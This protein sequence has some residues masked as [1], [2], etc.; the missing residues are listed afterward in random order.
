MTFVTN[1]LTTIKTKNVRKK[2]F[3]DRRNRWLSSKL[4]EAGSGFRCQMVLSGS[5]LKRHWKI[6]L[7]IEGFILCWIPKWREWISELLLEM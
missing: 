5:N 1:K 7:Q 4:T 3:T 6:R 2:P